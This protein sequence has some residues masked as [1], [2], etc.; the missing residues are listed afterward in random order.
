MGREVVISLVTTPG[1]LPNAA[2]LVERLRSTHPE[3]VGI[4]HAT[5]GSRAEISTGLESRTLWGRPYLLEK[6]AGITLKVS[7]DAF[8]Q[9]N[10]LM[11]HV[12]YGLVA[13][14][15]G[16]APAAPGPADDSRL[17]RTP[18]T[19]AGPVVWDLYSGVGAIGLALAGRA[20]AVLGIESVPAAVEDALENARLNGIENASFLEGDVS[21]ILREVAEGRRRLPEE[22]ERPDVII[23]DPPRAGLT[24]KAT[25]R[26]G[27][28]AAPR[29]VYVSCNPATMAANVA[30]LQEYGYRLDRVTPVDMFPHTPHVEAVGLLLRDGHTDWA[31]PTEGDPAKPGA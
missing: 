14:E 12:L 29:I 4:V 30:L 5:N 3:V 2:G 31:S 9:T 11:A 26:I 1:D 24:T 13:H 27:E 7:I 8:F 28:T 21:T 23:V 22:L 17:H 20:K 6:M 25:S 18:P 16:A 15:A 10:T 19:P